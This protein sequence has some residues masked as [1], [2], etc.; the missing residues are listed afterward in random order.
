MSGEGVTGIARAGAQRQLVLAFP[1]QVRFRFDDFVVGG[2]AEVV[3]SLVDLGVGAGRFGGGLVTGPR[4]SGKTHLLQAAC[5]L[6]GDR[7][8]GAIYLPLADPELDPAL[9]EGLEH[10]A[11]VA[12]DDVDRWLGD[13]ERERALLALYQ[14]LL[15]HG[16][17]LLVATAQ[18]P[19]AL[20]ARFADLLSRLRALPVFTLRALDDAGRA[21][22]L[23]RLAGERGLD[24]DQGVLDFWLARGT[25]DLALLIEQLDRLDVAALAEQ[26]RL[27]IPLLKQVLE[28]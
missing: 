5:R 27:T 13:A 16:A 19:G 21:A 7:P 3:Q 15:G 11:L 1:L 28:L 10:C 6:H 8:G 23:R 14:G 18:A 17:A 25:R 20:E 24:L 9:L 4:G 26:R 2:N 22:V 12:L